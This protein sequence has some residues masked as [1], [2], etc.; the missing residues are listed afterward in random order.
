MGVGPG[1]EVPVERIQ[2][3]GGEVPRP[4]HEP[5]APGRAELGEEHGDAHD[6]GVNGADAGAGLE[7]AKSRAPEQVFMALQGEVLVVVGVAVV[8]LK[9]RR[10]GEDQPP[11][12]QDA[13]HLGDRLM[14]G[15]EVLDHR[16]TVDRLDARV[17]VRHVVGVRNH[18]HV[19]ERA[20]VDV[21]EFPAPRPAA[22]RQADGPGGLSGQDPVGGVRRRLGPVIADLRL[23]TPVDQPAQEPQ[24]QGAARGGRVRRVLACHPGA[25]GGVLRHRFRVCQENRD[26]AAQEW[27]VVKA[28]GRDQVPARRV[29]R[30]P[31]ARLRADERA[32][33]DLV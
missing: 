15:V 13:V 2:V 25:V 12:L 5:P 26:E 31:L 32:A 1:V 24:G 23:A 33:A 22:D 18:V 29:R 8:G 14:R 4:R 11:R 20:D 10:P 21:G 16:L 19:R 27:I 6:Q 30:Q 9:E 3:L 28:V 7:D 17:G